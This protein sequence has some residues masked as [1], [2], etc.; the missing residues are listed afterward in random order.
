MATVGDW[1]IRGVAGE[2][3]PCKPDIFDAA[4][5]GSEMRDQTKADLHC[6]LED[7]DDPSILPDGWCM[8]RREGEAGEG[9]FGIK[10]LGGSDPLAEL[11]AVKAREEA[12]LHVIKPWDLADARD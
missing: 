9:L 7:L 8:I 1:I 12:L 6:A 5:E 3:Y 2:F 4:Y 10:Y 11:E